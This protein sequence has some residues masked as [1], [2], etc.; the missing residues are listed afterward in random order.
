MHIV[1]ETYVQFITE[2]DIASFT[3]DLYHIQEKM[4]MADGCWRCCR[5]VKIFLVIYSKITN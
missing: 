2:I 1:Q 4:E 5:S 3:N